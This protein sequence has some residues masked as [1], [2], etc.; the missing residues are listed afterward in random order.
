M[1]ILNVFACILLSLHALA[2]NYTISLGVNGFGGQIAYLT[3]VEGDLSILTD[4]LTADRYGLFK[5]TLSDEDETG[6][7]KFI[8]PQLNNAEV[9]FIFNKENVTMSTEA[10][11]PNA[12]I[13]VHSSKENDLYY[14]FLA[15]DAVFNNQVE[16][17]EMI[18][19]NYIGDEFRGQAEAE[20]S[21]LLK[22]YYEDLANLQR[23]GKD[24]YAWKVIKSSQTPAAPMLLSQSEKNAFLK[25]HNFDDV[26]FSDATLINSEVFTSAAIRYLSI[27]SQQIQQ[28]NKNAIFMAAVDT[29]LA[30][31]SVNTESYNFV[32]NYLLGGFESMSATEIVTYISQK[33]LSENT[34]SSEDESTLRRK[35][36]NNTALA[37]GKQ[38]PLDILT[39][40]N[41][42]KDINFANENIALIFWATWCGHCTQAMPTI[43][44]HYAKL[45]N[46]KYKLVTLSLDTTTTDWEKFIDA[47]PNFQKA[48]NLIDTNGWDGEAADAYYIYGTP[49][50]FL[51]QQGKIVGK[52][53]EAEELFESLKRLKWE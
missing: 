50:I 45:N 39:A 1:K 15:K 11:N 33:Y 51:I 12:Y 14:T 25:A 2:T 6:F 23:Q 4:T 24:T 48:K 37:V 44:N 31:A 43:L 30:K 10:I 29:I 40:M 41:P 20:Y 5:T 18:Y 53:I 34:C 32:V 16:L 3:K 19:N 47:H 17:V 26:D 9:P 13:Q 35:A 28:S 7:Y 46:P 49:T 38:A 36:M 21:R 22:I 42:Q 52:P 27:Y 8:F